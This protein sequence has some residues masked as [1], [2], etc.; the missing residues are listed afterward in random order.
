MKPYKFSPIKN[1]LEL[2][3]AIK[4]IHIQC[5]K[6][7]KQSL[8]YYLP[9]AG[10]VGIFCHYDD[11]Y[12]FLTNIREELT[13]LSNNFRQKYFRLHT[14][15]VIPAFDDIPQTSYTYLYARKPDPTHPQ[16]GDIDFVLEAEKFRNLKQELLDGKQIKDARILPRADLDLIE[17]CDPDIDALGYIGS[18]TMEEAVVAFPRSSV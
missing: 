17:L 15:I 14:P 6:L 11:E 8:G 13:D 18:Q 4:Y 5:H 9:I 10:N 2:L 16:V 1:E 7:C 3:A 12:K